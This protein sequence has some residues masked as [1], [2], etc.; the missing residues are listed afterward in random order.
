MPTPVGNNGYRIRQTSQAIF[1]GR[2][3]SCPIVEPNEHLWKSRCFFPLA[4]S[5]IILISFNC[6]IQI[7]IIN[8]F[9]IR[10]SNEEYSGKC[11]SEC[12]FYMLYIHI[13]YFIRLKINSFS[14]TTNLQLRCPDHL[15]QLQQLLLH[16]LSYQIF[17]LQDMVN[18]VPYVYYQYHRYN[19]QSLDY[20]AP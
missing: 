15:T 8:R 3:S 12:I 6:L 19:Q 11:K 4:Q 13:L 10:T 18:D 14:P 1:T 7:N 2:G 16:W 5:S 9:H 20:L 17:P